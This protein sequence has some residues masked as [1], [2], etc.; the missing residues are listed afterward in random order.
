[1]KTKCWTIALML[2][3]VTA[4][5]VSDEGQVNP[6]KQNNTTNNATNNSTNNTTN[7]TTNNS[8]NNSTTTPAVP[9]PPSAAITG[10]SQVMQSASYKTK[11]SVGAPAANPKPKSNDHQIEVGPVAPR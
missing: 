5:N 4:C 9:L 10:G 11:V 8:T 6:V 3:L 2:L 7:N 1:M